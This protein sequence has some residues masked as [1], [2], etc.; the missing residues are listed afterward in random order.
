MGLKGKL[1]YN[2]LVI[3]KKKEIQK[4]NKTIDHKAKI[5]TY[6][7]LKSLNS[8]TATCRKK[9]KKFHIKAE[10]GQLIWGALGHCR[11]CPAV[12]TALIVYYKT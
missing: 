5:I 12:V 11:D 3:K 7:L 10:S 6:F 1:Y 8:Y 4:E 9:K 2:N